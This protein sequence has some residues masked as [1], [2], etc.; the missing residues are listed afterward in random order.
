MRKPI[1]SG[2]EQQVRDLLIWMCDLVRKWM[3][4]CTTL[5]EVFELLLIEQVV[6]VKSADLKIWIRERKPTTAMEAGEL[7]DQY[8]QARGGVRLDGSK[9][10]KFSIERRRCHKCKEVGHQ[11]RDCP[12]SKSSQ[13]RDGRNFKDKR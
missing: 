1:D 6:N 8:M 7:K 2:S 10:E 5:D 3:K 9:K 12:K 4:E 11:A 13:G